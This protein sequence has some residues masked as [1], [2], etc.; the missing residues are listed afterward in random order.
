VYLHRLSIQ[1]VTRIS[2]EVTRQM[3]VGDRA[4][5]CL[6]RYAAGTS[7]PVHQHESEQFAYILKGR[8]RFLLDSGPLDAGP[9]DIVYIPSNAPHGAEV[10]DAAEVIEVFSPLRP[11]F[12]EAAR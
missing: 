11:E 6:F 12:L 7:E 3:V 10:L 8:V 4:M 1:P 2:P 5:M 9:G